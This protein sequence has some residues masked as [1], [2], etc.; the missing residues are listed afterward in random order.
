[1]LQSYD[2]LFASSNKNKYLEAK[3]I[4]EVF[5]ISLGFYKC[6]L[7]EIQSDTLEEI[8]LQKIYHAFKQCQK[9]VIIE[10]DGLFIDTLKGFPGPYSSYVFQTI[11]NNGI[12]KLLNIKRNASFRSIIAYCDSVNGELLFKGKINGKISKHLKG[13]GW[14]Y[15]PIFIPSGKSMTFGEMV[16]KNNISHRYKA[17][18]KFAN[19]FQNK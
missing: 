12:L 18:K 1:M 6:T 3:K 4:L 2:V 5:G 7:L 11:G 14:G 13:K 16:D 8:A 9:P 10:D 19:W 15:D 17:L